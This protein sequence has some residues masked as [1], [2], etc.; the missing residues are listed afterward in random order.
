MTQPPAL[1]ARESRPVSAVC[2]RRE[3][4]A[5][6]STASTPGVR[7]RMQTQ[8]T[9]DTGPELAVRR[10]LHA[11]GLRYRV[12]RAPLPGLRRRADIVFGPCR[13]TTEVER[14]SCAV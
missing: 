6:A 5:A 7:R 12:D 3:A 4:S 11:V 1:A 14:R 2:T 13:P 8:R 10:R 9:R